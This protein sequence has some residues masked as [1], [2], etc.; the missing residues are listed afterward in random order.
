MW[1]LYWANLMQSEAGMF[2]ATEVV[3]IKKWTYTDAAN[4]AASLQLWQCKWRRTVILTGVYWRWQRRCCVSSGNDTWRKENTLGLQTACTTRT[5]GSWKSGVLW[6]G[7]VFLLLSRAP[8]WRGTGTQAWASHT[9]VSVPFR[10]VL[11]ACPWRSSTL[12]REDASHLPGAPASA[13]P[14]AKEPSLASSNS[15]SCRFFSWFWPISPSRRAGF[16][17]QPSDLSHRRQALSTHEEWARRDM[18]LIP[19][20]RGGRSISTLIS[21]LKPPPSLA[22][23]SRPV[24]HTHHQHQEW[25]FLQTDKWH[26]IKEH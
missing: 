9:D 13:P 25:T 4:L 23:I 5:A 18:G 14:P 19:L 15:S 24:F 7:F 3:G 2:T 22:V 6:S 11:A 1:A 17:Q 8:L 12:C 26:Q 21:L 10:R 16:P 20:I